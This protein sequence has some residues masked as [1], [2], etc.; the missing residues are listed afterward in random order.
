[1]FRYTLA[2]EKRLAKQGRTKEFNEEF[3][4]TMERGVFREITPKE[5]AELDGPVNYIS[6]VR[7]SR[8]APTLRH[9]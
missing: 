7:P 2:Q 3:Y 8:R 4:K 1:V 6:M 5:M 9:H